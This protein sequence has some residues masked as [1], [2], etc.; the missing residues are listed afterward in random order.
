VAEH[1]EPTYE[2]AETFEDEPQPATASTAATTARA[3]QS[4]RK[5]VRAVTASESS[6]T[7]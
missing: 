1:T 2:P 3:A 4:R 5:E 6:G 7:R